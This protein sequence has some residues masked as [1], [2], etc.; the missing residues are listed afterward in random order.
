MCKKILIVFAT[1]SNLK[2]TSIA[3]STTPLIKCMKTDVFYY[4]SD[5]HVRPCDS[6]F[7]AFHLTALIKP[8]W[9]ISVNSLA[10]KTPLP[11][12]LEICIDKNFTSASTRWLHWF[13]IKLSP[14]I[15]QQNCAH[16]WHAALMLLRSSM[17]IATRPLDI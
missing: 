6:A 10:F 4:K 13:H 11:T 7:C 8:N 16:V 15:L 12:T 14:H 9:C 1:I 5:M 17:K 2:K 3:L